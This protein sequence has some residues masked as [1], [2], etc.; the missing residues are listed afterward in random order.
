MTYVY[1]ATKNRTFSQYPM[2]LR[3]LTHWAKKK[4]GQT[5]IQYTRCTLQDTLEM[6]ENTH[7][8]HDT[9]TPYSPIEKINIIVLPVVC[10]SNGFV[11]STLPII[12][13]RRWRGNALTTLWPSHHFITFHTVWF[14]I[15]FY[16]LAKL[17]K[18]FFV[19]QFKG[20][21]CQK[22]ASPAG[23]HHTGY[24]GFI[25]FLFIRTHKQWSK[26]LSKY[27]KHPI[28]LNIF[29]RFCKPQR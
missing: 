6:H 4:N 25:P 21:Q 8:S 20:S 7:A 29:I 16:V 15:A 5:R 27:L 2:I 3:N 10:F 18:W 22:C 17:A 26:Y 11:I 13:I 14:L 1:D 9:S 12:K 24:G 19:A 28:Y 23:R